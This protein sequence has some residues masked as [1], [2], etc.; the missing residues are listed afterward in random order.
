MPDATT[1]TDCPIPDAASRTDCPMP[2]AAF[3]HKVEVLA[4][5]TWL[6]GCRE[7]VN[8]MQTPSK[9]CQNRIK[10]KLEQIS[11]SRHMVRVK[12]KCIAQMIVFL[13]IEQRN[14]DWQYTHTSHEIV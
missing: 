8:T 3:L 5:A 11:T 14:N 2:E 13:M 12:H 10:A 7:D 6:R 4:F 9:N 1:G